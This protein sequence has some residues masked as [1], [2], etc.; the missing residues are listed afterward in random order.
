[1][2]IV[3]SMRMAFVGYRK[4][5]STL[6]LRLCSRRSLYDYQAAFPLVRK[7]KRKGN[8]QKKI[9]QAGNNKQCFLMSTNTNANC[10]RICKLFVFLFSFFLTVPGSDKKKIHLRL[11]L[12]INVSWRLRQFHHFSCIF[13]VFFFLLLLS[14]HM[15]VFENRKRRDRKVGRVGIAQRSDSVNVTRYF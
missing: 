6:W 7:R 8:A 10:I 15:H 14:C 2:R 3:I 1:M 9:E 12:H 4:C 13:P 5:S 11:H